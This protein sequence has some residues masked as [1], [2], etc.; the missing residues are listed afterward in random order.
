M[1]KWI[2]LIAVGLMAAKCPSDMSL[3]QRIDVQGH[4]GCRGLMPENSIPGFLKAI[5]LGVH[6]L[7]MDVVI[8]KDRQVV[9]SHEPYMSAKIA[10]DPSGA[11]ISESTQMAFN[12]YQMELEEIQSYDCGSKEHP[13][14]PEQEKLKTYKP[15]LAEVLAQV[16]QLFEN[17]PDAIRYN[18]EIKRRPDWDGLY[19]PPV[20][21]FAALVVDVILDHGVSDRTVIQSFDPE[22]LRQVRRRAPDIA[23]AFLI[24]RPISVQAATDELGYVPAIYSPNFR[25]VDAVMVREVHAQGMKL[26]PWTVNDRDDIRRMIE[27]GIDGIIS[28][29]PNRV[30]AVLEALK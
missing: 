29:Y 10:M 3:S 1:T 16:E 25:L 14:Y 2:T 20:A 5:E 6:T 23:Q 15:A 24:D 27:L 21:E 9:V 8:S 11:R 28:D 4:R 30:F 26:I 22:S 13:D 18:I 17:R 19:H 7:E 12:L